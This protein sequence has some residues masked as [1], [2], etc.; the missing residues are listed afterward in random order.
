VLSGN[1]ETSTAYGAYPTTSS[2][3][4]SRRSNQRTLATREIKATHLRRSD[5]AVPEVSLHSQANTNRQKPGSTACLQTFKEQTADIA[6]RHSSADLHL[7]FCYPL[8]YHH[9]TF[10]PCF[11]FHPR[12]INLTARNMAPT[13]RVR[14]NPSLRVNYCAPQN[15]G[16][17][18]HPFVI[19]DGGSRRNSVFIT[20]SP[21]PKPKPATRSSGPLT[22]S[23]GI[24]KIKAPVKTVKLDRKLECDI[25]AHSR[26]DKLFPAEK[27]VKMC[28]HMTAVCMYCVEKLVKGM[29]EDQKLGEA[30]LK[31]LDPSCEHILSFENVKAI[32]RK[33]AFEM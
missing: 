32:V 28:A 19:A 29:V 12:L 31:C 10:P 33:N 7:H 13:T 5:T 30:R 4:S 11:P 14:D 1:S 2:S 22:R 25:C 8:H 24:T 27:G 16:T 17:R 9:L 26:P 18:E 3:V 20:D 15:R 21:K 23:A 6:S